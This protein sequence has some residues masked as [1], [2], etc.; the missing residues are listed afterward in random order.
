LLDLFCHKHDISTPR[1]AAVSNVSRQH[2]NRMRHGKA[3]TTIRTA[4]DL[5]KGASVIVRRKVAV[6]ELF[7]LDYSVEL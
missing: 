6:G 4:K 2:L 5:A 7:D 1:L 3:D